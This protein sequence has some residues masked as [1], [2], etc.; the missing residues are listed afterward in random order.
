V[1]LYAQ[2][3]VISL[4]LFN[5]GEKFRILIPKQTPAGGFSFKVS[6]NLTKLQG[7]DR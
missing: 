1:Y 2:S 7:I 4:N 3:L 6:G 5:V